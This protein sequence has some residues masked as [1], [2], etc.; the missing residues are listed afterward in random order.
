MVNPAPIAGFT[1]TT[2][3][4]STT[5]HHRETTFCTR[6]TTFCANPNSR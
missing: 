5:F 1:I 4:Q 2:L 3:V 6:F